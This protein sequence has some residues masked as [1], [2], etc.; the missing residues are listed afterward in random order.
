MPES[1]P[2]SRPESA[3]S[4][5]REPVTPSLRMLDARALRGLAHPLRMLLLAELRREGP[6]TASRLAERL[7]ESSG[8]TSYHLRQLAAHGFVEDAVGHGKG[9]ERW[10]QAVHEGTGFDGSLIHDTDPATSSAAALFLQTVA[11]N[12]TQEVSAWVAE[13]SARLGRWESGADLSDFTLRL[14][15]GQSEELIGRL[16]DVIN[17]YRDLPETEDTRTVRVHTHVLPRSASE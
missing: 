11:A 3:P 8:S 15:P 17:T 9:R 14:S 4:A 13:A 10:W 6:A 1:R 2:Q 5:G 12:H 16:H 7:G